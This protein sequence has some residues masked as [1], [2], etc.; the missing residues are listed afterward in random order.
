M[1]GKLL[2]LE[3]VR[4]ESRV[5]NTFLAG[6]DGSA[7]RI[8][9]KAAMENGTT[10][11]LNA[12]ELASILG[13]ASMSSA[14]IPVTAESAIRVSTVYA[15]IQRL[16]GSIASLPFEVYEREDDTQ[17]EASDHPYWWMLN[18]QANS[19]MTASTA[20]KLLISGQLFYGDGYAELL[21][22]SY[23]SSKVIG[24]RPLH[25]L[26]VTPFRDGDGN[27]YWRVQPLNGAAYVLDQADLIHLPSLGYDDELMRSPSPITYAARE[28]IGTALAADS[29]SGKFFTDGANFDYALKTA[30]DIDEEQL[31][32]LH[33]S[34]RAR[35][36]GARAP[37]ILTGGLEPAQLS[38]NSKDAEILATRLFGVEEICRI[39]GVPPHLVGHTEKNSSFGTGMA[40]QGGNY[41]RYTLMDRLTD[42]R[43][44]FNRKLWPNRERFFV[45]HKTE[46]LESGDMK[47]RFDAYRVAVGGSGQPGWMTP[48]QVRRA[49]KMPPIA[50]GDKLSEGVSTSETIAGTEKDLNQPA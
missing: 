21:R 7:E 40:E 48:N 46:A 28:Q 12:N 47:A 20:W 5:L 27:R 10:T 15:C 25:P 22:P 42:I 38:V 11:N 31:K 19:D 43:Q 44:E 32:M 41:V 30:A 35:R 34:L 3:A 4:H 29:F 14:G 8:G 49:E 1:T 26:R 2:N 17:K 36:A 24:W 23:Y 50:G 45:A 33:A 39:F 6:R 37:L 13:L 18:E 16:A 9:V